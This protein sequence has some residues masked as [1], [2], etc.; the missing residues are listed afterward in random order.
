MPSRKWSALGLGVS[1]ERPG[2][3]EL[4]AVKQELSAIVHDDKV[5]E[6][7][8]GLMKGRLLL[9]RE[10]TLEAMEAELRQPR[11]VVHI[12]SHFHFV[13]GNE[14]N[15]FLLLGDERPEFNKL[16]VSQF[17]HTFPPV[18][19]LVELLTLS[20]CDTATGGGDKED[21]SEFEG[22]G[23]LAQQKGAQSVIASLWAIDDP[24]TGA[25]MERFYRIRDTQPNL[26]KAEVL[27]QAQLSLLRGEQEQSSV[28]DLKRAEIVGQSE[29][30][31]PSGQPP[32]KFDPRAP[33]AHPYY[34]APFILI[35]N[36]R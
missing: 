30:S 16:F 1:E 14:E 3:H 27:R 25:L 20:A 23:A 10:F 6:T 35:G 34:W 17:K 26:S 11:Q 29:K 36:W 2:F 9:N 8:G 31:K 15:S 21:G 7:S 18:F 5:P 22:F 24:S 12:A 33:Y 19:S 13:P 28:Q 32:F 4:Q